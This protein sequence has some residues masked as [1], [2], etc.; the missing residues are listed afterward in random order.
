MHPFLD[1]LRG[2]HLLKPKIKKRKLWHPR[3]R[4][5]P[6]RAAKEN[7]GMTALCRAKEQA[8]QVGAAEERAP[9]KR[10]PEKKKHLMKQSETVNNSTKINNS[11]KKMKP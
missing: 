9:G 3:N 4:F 7:P 6:R 2:C 8:V 10:S 5:Q 11:R 1:I